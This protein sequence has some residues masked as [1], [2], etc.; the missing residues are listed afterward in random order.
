MRK[1]I[2]DPSS[3][4]HKLFTSQL[5]TSFPQPAIKSLRIIIYNVEIDGSLGEGGGQVLRTSLALAAVRGI[6]LK[7]FNIRK[8]RAKPG[9]RHQHLLG[10]QLVE[11]ITDG[12]V[13][14]ARVDSTEIEFVPRGLRGVELT[15]NVGT[16]GAVTLV[17]QTIL[18]PLLFAP[19]PSRVKIIGGTDVDMAPTADY[20]RNVFLPTIR[21][22]GADVTLKII[23]RGF[24]PAGGGI[25]LLEVKPLKKPLRALSFTRPPKEISVTGISVAGGL[26]GVAQ[27]QAKAAERMLSKKDIPV[28]IEIEER[29]RAE[30]LSPGSSITLWVDD[31]PI[32]ASALGAPGVPAEVVGK[33]AANHILRYLNYPLDPHMGDQLIP[34]LALA[35]DTSVIKTFLTMH[36]YT[37][38]LLVEKILGIEFDVEGGV[39]RLSVIKI[40]GLGLDPEEVREQ[41][42][43]KI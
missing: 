36:A 17:I 25:V 31:N 26:S 16:A 21:K 43:P 33:R 12:E 2:E 28:S 23:K 10:V 3:F 20:I 27:R 18:L 39:D 30:V 4:L 40:K 42:M 32:G 8:K 5:L 24:Y 1:M 7:I 35:E 11:K 38:L 15:A 41:G 37:N 6:P 9:L 22:M 34:F 29:L 14:G 19:E 13:K